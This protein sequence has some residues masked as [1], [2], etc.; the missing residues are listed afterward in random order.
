MSR[1]STIA[2]LL[3][4]AAAPAP[5]QVAP[6]AGDAATRSLIEQL[7][8][9]T[10]GIRLP[11]EPA[12][13]PAAAPA[14]IAP[15]PV[16]I[17]PV[18]PLPREA[19]MTTRPSLKQA[20]PEA[21]SVSITVNFPSGSA[22]ITPDAARAL[23]PLGRALASADL[24]AYRFRIEGHTDTVGDAWT[25]RQ[26]SERRAAAVRDHL[27]RSFGVDPRRLDAVGYGADQPA[28][29]TPPNVPELRNRRVQVV[30]IGG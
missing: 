7:R 2:A 3:L 16:P 5:A 18:P 21:P 23:A 26:L 25:N 4:L 6:P 19:A 9:G 1:A 22:A 28:V 29:P 24:A 8:P 27:S 12:V 10:R 17:A 30:N 13:D 15:G 11:T 20:E 14:A